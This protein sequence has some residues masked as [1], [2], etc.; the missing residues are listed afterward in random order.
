MKVYLSIL[1][2]MDLKLLFCYFH[3]QNILFL[4]TDVKE[5]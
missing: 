5:T 2:D 1:A 4:S 3:M